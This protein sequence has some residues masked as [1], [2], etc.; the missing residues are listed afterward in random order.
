M[1]LEAN[2]A[3]AKGPLATTGPFQ[4]PE[5]GPTNALEMPQNRTAHI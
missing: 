3:Y 1:Y 4:D 5:R 2:E